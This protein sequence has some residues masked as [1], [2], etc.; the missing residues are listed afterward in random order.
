MQWTLKRMQQEHMSWFSENERVFVANKSNGSETDTKPLKNGNLW[1]K[2][3][4]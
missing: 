4:V 3:D 1:E 2:Y